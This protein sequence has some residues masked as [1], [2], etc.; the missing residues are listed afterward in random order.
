ML[1]FI[2][3]DGIGLG[4]DEPGNPLA[5]TPLPTLERL[6]GGRM[7]AGRSLMTSHHLFRGLDAGLGVEGLPQSGTG[8]TTLFTGVNAAQVAGMHVSAY[9]TEVLRE[10]IAAF[11]LLKRAREAG[12][13]VT[14]ANAYSPY[15]WQ[16]A[17]DR[18][19]RHSATTWTNLAAGLPFRS[20][21]DLARGEAVYWD[22]THEV[23][24]SRYAP[25]LAPVTPQEAGRRL[26]ALLH[27][28]DLVLFESFLPD[29][30]GH[31]RLEWT[32]EQVLER[33]DGL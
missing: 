5:T 15:Y 23:A 31:R 11:S 13:R 8:Q 33:I 29:L 30:V 19:H 9:P 28:H 24:R 17:A 22:I 4:P 21:E 16:M 12:L 18:R 14:F 10:H 26:A 25:E 32:P 2:F 3:L 20:F 6:C 7:V 1:L 27:D